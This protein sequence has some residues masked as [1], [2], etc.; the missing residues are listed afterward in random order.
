MDGH[1]PAAREVILALLDK[2]RA[3]GIEEMADP[4]VFQ[5]SPFR[6]MGQAVGVSRRFGDAQ[7]LRASLNE[8]QARLYVQ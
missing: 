7:R 1:A 8:M 4:R 3:W 6:E 2:Y 5:L